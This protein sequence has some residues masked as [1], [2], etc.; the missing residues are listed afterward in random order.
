MHTPGIEP[1]MCASKACF[2]TICVGLVSCIY[3]KRNKSK[4]KSIAM[5]RKRANFEWTNHALTR[6][7]FFLG[8]LF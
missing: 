1:R 5:L 6:I 8:P 2:L 3:N 7:I 4:V